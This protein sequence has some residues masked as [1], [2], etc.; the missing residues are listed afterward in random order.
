M[1]KIMNKGDGDGG[2]DG[3]GDQWRSRIIFRREYT[4]SNINLKLNEK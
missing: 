4:I 1:V 3:G 2:C